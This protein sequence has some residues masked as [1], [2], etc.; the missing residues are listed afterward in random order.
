MLPIPPLTGEEVGLA[1]GRP[2][3][4]ELGVP[5]CVKPSFGGAVTVFPDANVIAAL[6]RVRPLIVAA[7]SN[8][9]D[10]SANMIPLNA[11]LVPM[12]AEEPTCQTTLDATA[13]LEVI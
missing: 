13:P 6:T 11:A 1:T 8:V 2:T 5:V 12:V 7:G 3:G 4:D 9:V 10:A